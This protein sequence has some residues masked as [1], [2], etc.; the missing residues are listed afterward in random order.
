MTDAPDDL[1]CDFCGALEPCQWTAH[2]VH[3]SCVDF[4]ACHERWGRQPQRA[5]IGPENVDG[6][7]REVV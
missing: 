3:W 7:G 1:R 2:G 6:D 4:R 5:S